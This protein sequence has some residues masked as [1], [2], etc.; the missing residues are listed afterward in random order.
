MGRSLAETIALFVA[1][2]LI[3]ALF[4][5][6]RARHPLVLGSWSRGALFWLTLGGLLLA[7]GGFIAAGLHEERIGGAYVP[8]HMEDGRLTPGYFK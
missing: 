4:L 6:F 1:P 7:I 8:A 3:Y 5:T 2:F